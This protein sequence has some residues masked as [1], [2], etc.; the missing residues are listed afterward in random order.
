MEREVVLPIDICLRNF[1]LNLYQTDL[2]KNNGNREFRKKALSLF[3]NKKLKV[4]KLNSKET[5]I[6]V[7]GTE[8]QDQ[9]A[10]SDLFASTILLNEL[11]IL[12]QTT[13][14]IDP[15][16]LSLPAVAKLDATSTSKYFS[17]TKSCQSQSELQLFKRPDTVLSSAL[18]SV[19]YASLIYQL[20]RVKEE[21][22]QL[23]QRSKEHEEKLTRRNLEERDKYELMI[24]QLKAENDKLKQAAVTEQ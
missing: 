5:K 19:D 16:Q 21:N 2:D 15:F 24:Q 9:A 1:K 13:D 22:R 18:N 14:A 3:I 6:V 20:R 7:E 10:S 12:N 23:V 8:D 11:K 17:R 4:N